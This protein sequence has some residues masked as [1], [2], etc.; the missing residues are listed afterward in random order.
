[1]LL[2]A[3]AA[4][5]GSDTGSDG[6]PPQPVHRLDPGTQAA[7]FAAYARSGTPTVLPGVATEANSWP[8]AGW[9]CE[10][11]SVD[12]AAARMRVE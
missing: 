12:F 8:M 1:L 3:A 2:S 6:P 11:I 9:S 5:A 7:A 10:Q 4:V